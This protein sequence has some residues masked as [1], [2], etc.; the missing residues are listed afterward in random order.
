VAAAVALLAP[1]LLVVQVVAVAYGMLL[2]ALEQLG[3][4]MLAAMAHCH[5]VM[6]KM[7]S[8]MV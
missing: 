2:E 4:G 3:K 6:D 5:L 1:G 8:L 7:D